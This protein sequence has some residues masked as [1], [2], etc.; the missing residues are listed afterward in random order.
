MHPTF[1]MALVFTRPMTGL[2]FP[3]MF[4]AV[5]GMLRGVRAEKVVGGVGGE[6]EDCED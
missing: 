3:I 1:L 2:H 4:L 6:C 5:T